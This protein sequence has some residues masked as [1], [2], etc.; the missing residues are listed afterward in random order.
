MAKTLIRRGIRSALAM[1][2]PAGIEN[3]GLSTAVMTF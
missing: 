3:G 2:N 1:A